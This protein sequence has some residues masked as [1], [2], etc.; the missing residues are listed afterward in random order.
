MRGTLDVRRM[1]PKQNRRR[2]KNKRPTKSQTDQ[3][4]L[5]PGDIPEDILQEK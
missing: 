5:I 4:D 3:A 1:L 2:K